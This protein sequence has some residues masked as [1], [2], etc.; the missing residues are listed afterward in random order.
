MKQLS[1]V[2]LLLLASASAQAAWTLVD[3]TNDAVVYV[4]FAPV[5]KQGTLVT[6]WFLFDLMAAQRAANGAEFVSM[7][8]Q[9]EYDCGEERRFRK[10]FTSFH[11]AKM[12]KGDIVDIDPGVGQWVPIPPGSPGERFWKKICKR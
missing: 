6:V 12:G 3:N 10:A 2:V 1:F 9:E 7:K 5:R 8:I 4:D 11:S